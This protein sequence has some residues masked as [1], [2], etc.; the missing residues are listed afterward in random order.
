MPARGG[1]GIR[2]RMT[3]GPSG[4]GAI[5]RPQILPAKRIMS[6]TLFAGFPFHPS[7]I[8]G[9]RLPR[10]DFSPGI[11]AP[12]DA[13][14]G[15]ADAHIESGPSHTA[16]GPSHTASG[17]S[18]AA[19][20]PSHTVSGSTH[21]KAGPMRACALAPQ[22]DEKPQ[23]ERE[24]AAALSHLNRTRRRVRRGRAIFPAENPIFQ[25]KNRFPAV[26]AEIL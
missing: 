10:T 16:S 13:H 4:R 11:R 5:H 3:V 9:K 1:A 19:S 2:A 22:T 24:R 12:A 7:R 20:G 14:K 23:G 26:S 18:H 6:E 15:T 21:I 25:R 8:S 17:Q